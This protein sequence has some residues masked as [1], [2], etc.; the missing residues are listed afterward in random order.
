[1]YY[2]NNIIN[3]IVGFIFLAII[4]LVIFGL[5]AAMTVWN[6]ISLTPKKDKVKNRRKKDIAT[7]LLGFC[8]T[9]VMIKLMSNYHWDEP[10]M[11]GGDLFSI[12]HEP[13]SSDYV[14]SL[15]LY[16]AVPIACMII[17]GQDKLLP[18]LAGA[19]CIGGIYGGMAN[20]PGLSCVPA[21]TA[22][23]PRLLRSLAMT[24]QGGF[25][26]PEGRNDK[27]ENR[28]GRRAASANPY[29]ISG[30][31]YIS[32][33]ADRSTHLGF[34]VAISASFRLRDQLF[35]CFSRSIAALTSGVV[36]K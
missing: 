36:S 33:S 34:I 9:A 26:H 28:C 15:L 29:A 1:M 19:F 21:C 6:I 23:L 8:L 7:L 17:A 10:V 13:F 11:L 30:N 32:H 27:S 4:C 14:L 3:T 25:P 16:A 35:I 18:P 31:C 22:R 2:V 12:L 24:S 20:S 5:P